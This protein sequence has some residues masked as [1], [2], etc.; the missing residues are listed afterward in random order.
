M[1]PAE[2]QTIHLSIYLLVTS[3]HPGAWGSGDGLRGANEQ[4]R[5]RLLQLHADACRGAVERA[6]RGGAAGD[7]QRDS[8]DVDGRR[9]RHGAGQVGRPHGPGGRAPAAGAQPGGAARGVRAGWLPVPLLQGW[10]EL[11]CLEL[12]VQSRRPPRDGVARRGLPRQHVPI[13]R[14]LP[15][16]RL[17]LRDQG[18]PQGQ[19]PRAPV[20]LPGA[21]RARQQ[22]RQAP[23]P[24]LVAHPGRADLGDDQAD[25]R[26][27]RGA[28]GAAAVGRRV[29]ALL[30]ARCAATLPPP[31]PH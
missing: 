18:L 1:R 17:L 15:G 4:L 22:E 25:A 10:Q 20:D 9:Q 5:R 13:L 12:Q 23:Q 29:G 27:H 11:R 30:L 31:P 7:E 26:G 28:Q 3:C 14:R 19:R 16:L 24:L 6:D 21:A 8:A 2:T